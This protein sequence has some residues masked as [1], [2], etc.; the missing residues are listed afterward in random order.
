MAHNLEK[1]SKAGVSAKLPEYESQSDIQPPI[2]ELPIKEG[3]EKNII[4]IPKEQEYPFTATIL[5][6]DGIKTTQS[7]EGASGKVMLTYEAT[8]K[9]S[10]KA[11]QLHSSITGDE[12]FKLLKQLND[13]LITSNGIG[14]S[15]LAYDSPIKIT[16]TVDQIQPFEEDTFYFFMVDLRKDVLSEG[17]IKELNKLLLYVPPNIELDP[18]TR[19]CNFEKTDTETGD[20]KLYKATAS[21]LNFVSKDCDARG[22]NKKECESIYKEENHAVCKFK[23][24]DLSSEQKVPTFVEFKAY[25]EYKFIIEKPFFVGLIPTKTTTSTD[26][27]KPI[28][29]KDKCIELKGCRPVFKEQTNDFSYC[30]EC[31]LDLLKC[32]D[33]P[34]ENDCTNDYCS[35][36]ECKWETSICKEEAI[37]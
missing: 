32:S 12:R 16:F 4:I 11:Y 29:D 31:P 2:I 5:F 15:A 17:N 26:A 28:I 27:C 20:I 22:V 25:A 14:K 3:A 33:Y 7:I 18:D 34:N 1:D 23:F 21:F 9:S 30:E 35:L 36:G 24:T 37:A 10:W 13:P 6:P 8:S 19:F